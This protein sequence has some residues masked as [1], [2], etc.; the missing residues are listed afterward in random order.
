M[1]RYFSLNSWV[2]LALV[3]LLCSYSA[4]C[5]PERSLPRDARD[6]LEVFAGVANRLPLEKASA[7]FEEETGIKVQLVTGGSGTVLSQMVTAKRG[8]LYVPSSE[9][10]MDLAVEQGVVEADSNKVVAYLIPAIAVQKGNPKG[11]NSVLDLKQADVRVAIAN[12]EVVSLGRYSLAIFEQAEKVR[13]EPGLAAAIEKKTV[14]KTKN[15]EHT[16]QVLALGQVDAVI[17]YSYFEVQNRE[18]IEIV[19]LN[20]KEIPEVGTVRIAVST[21]SENEA[22]ATEFAELVLSEEVQQ[23]Y[24][25]EGFVVSE[26]DARRLA[27]FSEIKR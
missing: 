4:G 26:D 14:T 23:L 21:Y 24:E 1:K 9:D 25:R 11:V 3:S 8:D 2:V 6:R 19:P 27:P 10:F 7:I 20:P 12:P 18:T 5:G 13:G 22:R 17:G 16:A 15:A